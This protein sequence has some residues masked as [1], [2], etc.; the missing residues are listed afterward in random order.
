MTYAQESPFRMTKYFF[1]TV[2][3]RRVPVMPDNLQLD[4]GLQL[5]IHSDKLPEQLQINLKAESKTPEPLTLLIEFVA[6]F[7][8]LE[9][10]P[11]ATQEQLE[12]FINERA[13][14]MMFPLMQDMIRRT[15][16]AMG[17]RPLEM[18]IPYRF[19]FRLDEMT[20]EEEE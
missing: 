9:G 16:A 3:L 7:E 12:W 14:Y 8:R 15:T 10:Q 18:R 11:E 6:L 2:D 19:E 13:L 20:R 4:L 5:G 17:M 1:T